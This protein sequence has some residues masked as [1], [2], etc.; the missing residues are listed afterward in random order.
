MRSPFTHILLT[1]LGVCVVAL[2]LYD[3]KYIEGKSML[4]TLHSH[5]TVFVYRWAYGAQ[6]PLIDRYF[7]QW[8]R[9]KPHELVF[10]RDPVYALPVVKR[11]VGV[12]GTSVKNMGSELLIGEV[13]IPIGEIRARELLDLEAIPEGKVFLLG[14]NREV[15]FDSRSYGLVDAD[16]ISGRVLGYN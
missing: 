2:A 1:A 13:S 3:V 6:P 8:G 12:G 16:R 7:I 9:I 15:S 10:L 4:P 11:C 14:D 5:Q